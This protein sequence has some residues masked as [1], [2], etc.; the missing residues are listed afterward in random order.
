MVIGKSGMK[1]LVEA[2]KNYAD[3][4]N[5]TK[6]QKYAFEEFVKELMHWTINTVADAK[7]IR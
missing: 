2:S 1:E 5:F 4:M 6:E 3:E 7:M